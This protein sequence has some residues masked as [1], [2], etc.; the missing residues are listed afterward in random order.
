MPIRP[1][2]G[3]FVSQYP[4]SLHNFHEPIARRT[5]SHAP[6]LRTLQFS[7]RPKTFPWVSASAL[8]QYMTKDPLVDWLKRYR[9]R[10]FSNENKNFNFTNFIMEK[11]VEFESEVIRYINDNIH[12]V[13][14][15]SNFYTLEGVETTKKLIREGVPFIHSAPLCNH[16]NRTKGIAD[17]LVRSD[18][19]YL[20][21]AECPL[22]EEESQIPAPK[23]EGD[24]HYVV[25]DIKWYTLDLASD[26]I[27]LLNSKSNPAYKAQI[28][29]YNQALGHIQGYTPR[30]GY[31]LGR[32][33]KY[34]KRDETF[35]GISCLD[36][37][38]VIDFEGRDKDYS[39]RV[40]N[41][42]KWVRD[43]KCHGAEW[44]INPP[45]R[46]E[47]YPNMCVDSGKWNPIK[48]KIANDIGEI[49]LLWFAGVR[50]RELAFLEGIRSWRDPEC[51]SEKIGMYGKRA[52]VVDKIIEINRSEN[53][54][55]ISPD[56]IKNNFHDWQFPEPNELF[57]DFETLADIF[58]PFSEL[59]KQERT[60]RIFMIGVGRIVGGEWVY[61]S[62][63]CEKPTLE[64]EFRIMDDFADY[65]A[66]FDNPKLFY[67]HAEK[68]FWN[69]YANRQFEASD[70]SKQN[71]ILN[72]WNLSNWIDICEIFR[73]EPIVIKGC[74]GF[75]LKPIARQML[76]YEMINTRLESE[77]QSGMTAM[78]RAWQAYQKSKD[79]VKSSVMLDIKKYNEFD[80]RV[81]YDILTYLRRNHT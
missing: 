71:I 19:L 79:P 52:P 41:A 60:D 22:S 11:G 39:T 15:V 31:I 3:L 69:K 20:L 27:H 40:K 21:T 66:D 1:R 74:F 33:W 51:S 42:I 28:Y 38:G 54:K 16:Y 81:M 13:V 37:L 49:S 43:V 30:Y 34:K 53:S 45:S 56:I 26:G 58:A 24:Y 14:T 8:R 48:E 25:I 63:I 10:N 12:E 36:K 18:F 2:R 61:R 4:Q 47:L 73:E 67:W 46:P 35:N 68:N 44:D 65:V 64:E 50:N 62:F 7:R 6:R 80:C 59:P 55:A 17:I 78:V 75:G 72:E 32:R 5:R 9:D 57:V 23:L 77:C 76:K 70:I 29:I